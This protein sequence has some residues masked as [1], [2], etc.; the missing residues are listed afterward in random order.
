[1]RRIVRGSVILLLVLWQGVPAGF[2]IEPQLDAAPYGRPLVDENS[3]GV[4]WPEMRRIVRVEVAFAEDAATL[5]PKNSMQVQ[6]WGGVWNGGPLRRYGEQG[7]GSTGWA[8]N[9]DWFN[10]EWKTADFRV[11]LDK[12]HRAVIFTFA[13]SGQKEFPDLKGKGVAYRPTLKIR[14]VFSGRHPK[15]ATLHAWT[16]SIFQT[17]LIDVHFE[18]RDE[19]NDAQEV[20]NGLLSEQWALKINGEC[21]LRTQLSYAINSEDSEA[22]RTLVT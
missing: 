19:C 5:P 3:V 17:G 4:E 9:D 6:Y 14:V 12:E 2:P 16:D 21:I 10:G 13:S 22:D 8:P 20:Y 15:A 18:N 1:M 7:A 11:D